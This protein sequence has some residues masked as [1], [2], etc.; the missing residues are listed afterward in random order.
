MYSELSEGD[1][2][3]MESL[4]SELL[5]KNLRVEILEKELQREDTRRQIIERFLNKTI[6]TIIPSL[7]T[8]EQTDKLRGTFQEF[9]GESMFP[10]DIGED[11]ETAL[12]NKESDIIHTTLY[13]GDE[14]N[15]NE[16][17]E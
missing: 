4:R 3:E 8:I 5:E 6:F 13:K 7:T 9:R 2:L 15:G 12:K 10:F 11:V 14:T 17:P 16:D 1:H